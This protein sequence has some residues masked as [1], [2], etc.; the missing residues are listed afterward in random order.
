MPVSSIRKGSA[1]D[2]ARIERFL[3]QSTIPARVA[4]NAGH[5]FPLLNSLWFEYRDD[6]LWFATHESSAILG[7]LRRDPRCAFEIAVNEPPYCGVRGQARGEI[8]RDGAGELL[9]RLIERYLG[10]SNPDLSNWLLGRSEQ[11]CLICLRPTWLT[12][13]DYS[14]RMRTR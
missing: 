8:S 14:P 3:V 2:A 1:W 11:E 13:W 9:E 12:A 7:F 6:S 5:G 4:C 10:D